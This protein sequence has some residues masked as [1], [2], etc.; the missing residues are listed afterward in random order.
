LLWVLLIAA[1]AADQ[2]TTVYGIRRYGPRIEANP[3]MRTVW[4]RWG[5][6]GLLLVQ[7]AVLVP[8]MALAQIY[9]PD[10]AWLIPL[11]VLL[12]AANNVRV[13][14]VKAR[15]RRRKAAATRLQPPGGRSSEARTTGE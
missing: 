9:S 2:I 15:R 4:K 11:I 14:A 8:V 13:V 1:I 5:A 7:V 12:A 10:Y 6:R 3:V